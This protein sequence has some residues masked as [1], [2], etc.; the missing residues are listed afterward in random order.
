[1]AS[2]QVLLIVLAVLIIGVT[3][4]VAMVFF[5][6]QSAAANRDGLTTDL[7]NFSVRAHQYYV[8]PKSWGGGEKSF[9]GLT[10]DYVTSKPYN[11]HGIFSIVSVT[12]TEVVMR[13][14]GITKGT[15]GNPIT[16]T[17]TVYSD[18]VGVSMSNQS[19]SSGGEGRGTP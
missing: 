17:M 19:E 4:A 1:M 18:S 14:V 8:R 9:E 2:Q 11:A 5:N 16:V 10:M 7:L 13:G 12:P 3:I 15:D 6:D